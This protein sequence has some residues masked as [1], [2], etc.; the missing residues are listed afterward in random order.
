MALAV[1]VVVL[2]KDRMVFVDYTTSTAQTILR[3]KD[4]RQLTQVSCTSLSGRGAS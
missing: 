3:R 2:P 1:C 4:T